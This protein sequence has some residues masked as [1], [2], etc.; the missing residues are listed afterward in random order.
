MKILVVNCGS[1]TIKF[2]LI[3][4]A[5]ESV[6]AK[7]RCDKIGIPD[8]NFIY[9][10]VRD[11]YSDN[12]RV[13]MNNHKEA[14]QVLLNTLLSGEHG[15]I[16]SLDEITAVG[17]RVVHGAE[18][19]SKSMLL[20]KEV[21]E[22]LH[23]LIELAP[24]HNPACITGIEA[25]IE[26]AP[27]M[28]NVAIFDT[29]FHQTMPDFNYIYAIP[30]EYYEKYGVRRYGFHGTSFMYVLDRVAK[31]LDKPKSEVNCIICHIG[32]GASI[33]AIKD[34]Q[35]YDTSMG[36]TPLEGLVMESRSGDMD[37]AIVL[38]IMEKENLTMKEVSD[39]LNKKSGRIGI[40]GIGDQRELL[41]SMENGNEQAAL[42]NKIQIN[43]TKKY[44]GSYMAEL[45]RVDAIVFTG[46]IGEN[47]ADER[48]GILKDM[49]NLGIEMDIEA[50]N[51]GSGKESLVSA[52]NSKIPVWVIPTNEE[53]EI[54][55]QTVEVIGKC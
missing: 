33:C 43:R 22:E 48:Y 34:G 8:A 20:S 42:A 50:N 15:V 14:M 28:K 16:K 13:Q 46:G 37:P 52:K 23:K 2:Q 7:G 47:N 3:D 53:V 49:E 25:I 1:T 21:L 12:F 31:V 35:S 17:H 6:I 29:A 55:R 39:I 9:K 32:G 18:K 36:L 44:V 26:V 40:C 24:L 5:D 38:K 51:A 4:M 30:Y 41:E 10:N 45:N 27:N 54:A 11:N 19:F